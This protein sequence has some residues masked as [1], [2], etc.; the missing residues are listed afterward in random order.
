VTASTRAREGDA[1]ELV[2]ETGA[3]HFF[4]PATGQRISR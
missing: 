4:D 1:I 2:V 3:L